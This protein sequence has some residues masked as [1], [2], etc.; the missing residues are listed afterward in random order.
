MAI[1]DYCLAAV[2]KARAEHIRDLRAMMG[3][4]VKAPRLPKAVKVEQPA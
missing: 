2:V 4:P 1:C 3:K